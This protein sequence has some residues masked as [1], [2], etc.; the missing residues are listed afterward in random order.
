MHSRIR[1]TISI[2]N[3]LDPVQ[4]KFPRS[5]TIL[6]MQKPLLCRRLRQDPERRGLMAASTSVLNILSLTDKNPPIPILPPPLT[7]NQT[8]P[9]RIQPSLPKQQQKKP[10]ITLL[11]PLEYP[12]ERANLQITQNGHNNTRILG[13]SRN[14]LQQR[15]V[16]KSHNPRTK[17]RKS[18]G[19]GLCRD[20]FGG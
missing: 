17:G 7:S 9:S 10:Q 19:Y 20:V 16:A 8:P 6:Y 18:A 4:S 3:Y 1:L 2:S 5:V 13:R 15:Q 12:D 14:S 11:P